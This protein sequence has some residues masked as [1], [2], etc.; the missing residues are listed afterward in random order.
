[1]SPECVRV[2]RLLRTRG[3]RGVDSSDFISHPVDGLDNFTRLAAR[4]YDL[5]FKHGCEIETRGRRGKFA[6]YVLVSERAERT[7]SDVSGTPAP[8]ASSPEVPSAE[9]TPL[10]T[11]HPMYDAYGDAA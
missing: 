2:L 7:A 10:F 8:D 1:M 9:P 3:D 4:I 5:K 6:V 11:S